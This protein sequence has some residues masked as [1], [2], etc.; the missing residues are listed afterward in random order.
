LFSFLVVCSDMILKGFCVVAF[1]ASAK[2]SSICILLSCLVC[3]WS[4]DFVIN[5]AG[6]QSFGSRGCN[7]KYCNI[8]IRDT[9]F[10]NSV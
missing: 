2:T 5:I 9:L 4:V 6:S 1:F 7:S 8:V 10:G 3:I